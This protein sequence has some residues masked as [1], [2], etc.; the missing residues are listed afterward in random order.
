MKIFL[1][2]LQIKKRIIL[3]TDYSTIEKSTTT[4]AYWEVFEVLQTK[5]KYSL[6]ENLGPSGY[7]LLIPPK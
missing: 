3:E 7:D 4:G 1:L 6:D 2:I 5:F